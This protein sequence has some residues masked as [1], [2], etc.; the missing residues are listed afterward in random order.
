M[1]HL[2][3]YSHP[4]EKVKGRRVTLHKHW[5]G[6]S[7]TFSVRPHRQPPPWS[8]GLLASWPPVWALWFWKNFSDSQGMRM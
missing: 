1:K 7:S 5:R 4:I 3:S 2:S 6:M 8:P